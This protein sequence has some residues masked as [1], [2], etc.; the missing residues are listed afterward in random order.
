MELNVGQDWGLERASQTEQP[1][2][3]HLD[4]PQVEAKGGENWKIL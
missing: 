3:G 2:L 4:Q 1:Q